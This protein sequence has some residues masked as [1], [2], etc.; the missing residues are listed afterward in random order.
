MPPPP[1]LC[2]VN[3]HPAAD[4]PVAW[5]EAALGRALPLVLADPGTDAAAV[6]DDCDD[7]EICLVDDPTIARVHVDFMGIDGATDVITFHHGEIVVSLDTAVRVA[8]ELG[9]PDRAEVLL[10]AIHG[11]L[12]LNGYDDTTPTARDRM[13]ARQHAIL[14]AVVE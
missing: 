10:Y 6:L 2:L 11:L 12:H 13:H 5:L 1:E 8:G 9:L 3:L 7:I 14:A 4:F